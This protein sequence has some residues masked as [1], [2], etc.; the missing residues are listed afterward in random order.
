MNTIYTA[1]KQDQKQAERLNS[2]RQALE[3]LNENQKSKKKENS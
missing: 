3:K 2:Y 1:K